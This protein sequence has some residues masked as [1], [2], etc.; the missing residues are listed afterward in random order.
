MG[1]LSDGAQLATAAGLFVLAGQLQAA[2][3]TQ[4]AVFEHTFSDRY[5]AII[6][7]L[8]FG[9]VIGSVAIPD[10]ASLRHYYDYFTLCE[11]ELYYRAQ[12]KVS[13]LTWCDWWE[14]I[15]INAN[16]PA[17]A[18]AWQRLR[19]QTGHFDLLAAAFEYTASP[20][21]GSPY[22]PPRA[23]RRSSPL[24]LRPR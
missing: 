22:D 4:R 7:R 14:G 10:D 15:I 21:S 23:P 3:S 16:R 8:P 17:F 5:V 6:D 20:A 1:W 13:Y 12:R 18:G 2:R 11:E 24:R 9:E 19:A